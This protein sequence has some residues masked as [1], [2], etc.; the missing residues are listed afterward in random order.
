MAGAYKWRLLSECDINDPFLIH[1]NT[2]ILNLK[3]GI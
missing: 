2:I 1:L 3:I